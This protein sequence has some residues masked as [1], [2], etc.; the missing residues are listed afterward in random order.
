[1]TLTGKSMFM[2][3]P[4]SS[5]E[6]EKRIRKEND[7]VDDG[8]GKLVDRKTYKKENFQ[9]LMEGN[10]QRHIDGLAREEAEEKAK[11]NPPKGPP[12]DHTINTGN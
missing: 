1:M 6:E 12:V 8:T 10:V 11:K 7:K 2:A 9:W 4:N 3:K 5:F